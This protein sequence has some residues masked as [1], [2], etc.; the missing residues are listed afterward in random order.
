M[1][2]VRQEDCIM[3][4]LKQPLNC[5]QKSVKKYLNMFIIYILKY[6]KKNEETTA[7]P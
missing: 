3:Q 6:H 2:D 4:L 7:T 5:V 1:W